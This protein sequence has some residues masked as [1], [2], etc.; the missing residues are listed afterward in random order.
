MKPTTPLL[1][2]ASVQVLSVKDSPACSA[3]VFLRLLM[4]RDKTIAKAPKIKKATPYNKVLSSFAAS[5]FAPPP[6]A[7]LAPP[8]LT[9]SST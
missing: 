9:V 1:V 4:I 3:D 6:S 2:K 7:T 5:T 8:P